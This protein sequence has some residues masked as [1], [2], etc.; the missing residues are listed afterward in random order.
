MRAHT[1]SLLLL[2]GAGCVSSGAP[3]GGEPLGEADAGSPGRADGGS[4]SLPADAGHGDAP[5]DG[6][7]SVVVPVDAGTSS[8]DADAGAVTST[9]TAADL[10]G[11]WAGTF[12]AKVWWTS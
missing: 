6:G 4:H 1:L 3:I 11:R 10:A 5:A 12:E 7:V 8:G 9:C 2:L